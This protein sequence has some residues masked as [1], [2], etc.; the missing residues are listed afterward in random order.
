M[1]QNGGGFDSTKHWIWTPIGNIAS[2][3]GV[4]AGVYFADMNGD[5]KDDYVFLDANGRASLWLNGGRGQDGTWRWDNKGEIASGVGATREEIRLVDLD[6][7]GKADYIYVDKSTGKMKMWRNGGLGSDGTWIWTAVGEIATGVGTTGSAVRFADFG[8]TGRA[9]YLVIVPGSLGV[10]KW[11]NT[12]GSVSSGGGSTVTSVSVSVSLS[13][14][15]STP[16]AAATVN[17]GS[18]GS[19]PDRTRTVDNM[20][21]APTPTS[22]ESS[23]QGSALAIPTASSPAKSGTQVARSLR[24]GAISLLALV[25]MAVMIVF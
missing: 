4:G 5:G 12:C 16:A 23:G 18:M 17:G 20:N 21:S 14:I 9:D 8:G 11:E 24:F 6:G 7:D 25:L 10:K 22:N 19:I 13:V 2:G 1:W 3:V 15:V